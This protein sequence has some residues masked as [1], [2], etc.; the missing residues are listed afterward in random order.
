MID[1][2]QNLLA[3]H[4]IDIGTAATLTHKIVVRISN[5]EDLAELQQ[6]VN[7]RFNLIS[8]YLRWAIRG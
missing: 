7:D 6:L 4:V 3:S 5:D 8:L 2:N 1:P